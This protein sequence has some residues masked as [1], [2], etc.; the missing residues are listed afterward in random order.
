MSS[1]CAGRRSTPRHPWLPDVRETPE[2][3]AR[4]QTLLDESYATSGAH[5]RS[6]I[7]A[8][9]R[10][11][12]EEVCRELQGM[13]LLALATVTAKGEPIVG[14]VDG[15]F[16]HGRFLFGSAENSVRFRHIRSRPQVSAT[17]LRG[18]ELVVTVHGSAEE[19]DKSV[20]DWEEL[21]S[22]FREVYGNDWDQ[23]GFWETAP[24]AFIE[25]RV[26]FAAS[27]KGIAQQ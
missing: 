3:I 20:G 10:L 14:P 27:F 2:E 25:P 8:E 9:R 24:Y 12:A 17:H 22:V 15:I 26:M 23:W 4:L 6:I 13:T 21:K 19:I 16:F 11:S 5:L 7:T 1:S 18:E